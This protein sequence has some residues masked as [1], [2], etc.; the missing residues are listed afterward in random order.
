MLEVV[1]ME[2]LVLDGGEAGKLVCVL[3]TAYGVDMA[4]KASR[5]CSLL[6]S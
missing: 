2:H 1:T 6:P 3:R 4:H 5:Q